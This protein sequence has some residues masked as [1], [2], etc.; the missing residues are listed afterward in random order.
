MIDDL[1][2]K[3]GGWKPDKSHLN[4][5]KMGKKQLALCVLPDIDYRTMLLSI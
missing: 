4:N 5:V 1:S 2:A 3:Y